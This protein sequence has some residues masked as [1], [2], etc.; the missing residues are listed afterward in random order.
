MCAV[1]RPILTSIFELFKPGPGPSSS[2]T[3]GPMSAGL[4]FRAL[5]ESLPEAEL[6]RGVRLTVR[7]LG[8]LSATGKGHGTDRAVLTGLLGYAPAS[9][10]AHLPAGVFSMPERDRLLRL[11]APVPPLGPENVIFDRVEHTHPFSNTLI[12][13]LL[14]AQDAPVLERVYYSVGG[15]FIQWEGWSAP[16][17]GKP[18]YPFDSAETLC[19]LAEEKGLSLPSILMANE[20]ALSGKSRVEVMEGLDMLIE[21]MRRAVDRGSRAEGLLPGELKVYRKAARLAGRADRMDDP[22]NRF[23]GLLN[24]YAFAVAEENA[25]GGIIVTA[26]TCGSAGVMAAMLTIMEGYLGFGPEAVRGG[27]MVAAAVGFLAK[28][29]AGIAGAEVGC[30]GEVGVASAMAA[31]MLAQARGYAP[32]VVF[33]AAEIALEHHLGL[34]CDPVG[35]Y[36]QIPCIERNAMGALKAYNAC[37]VAAAEE[38]DKHRVSLDQAIRAMGETGQDMNAKYKETS[39]GGLAASVDC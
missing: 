6:G 22:L 34:T 7:L 31:A 24:A 30:Q 2:H 3:I 15:G 19:C 33:N 14:D 35:G 8:S 13:S 12:C 38:T 4:D 23:L 1:E 20:M 28:R 29:H 10:P 18:P 5:L 16:E 27:L 37:L 32:A 25:A 39:Q 36:V 9:C 17:R 11:S 26:P 21:V